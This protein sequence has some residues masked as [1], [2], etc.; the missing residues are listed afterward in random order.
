MMKAFIGSILIVLSTAQITVPAQTQ[1]AHEPQTFLQNQF[2]FTP[3]ELSS[4]EQEQ[5]IVET[6]VGAVY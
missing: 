2:A 3:N 1:S 6:V 4:L 5:I